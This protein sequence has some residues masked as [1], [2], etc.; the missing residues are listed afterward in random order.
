MET[1]EWKGMFMEFI[2]LPKIKIQDENISKITYKNKLDK[3]YRLLEMGPSLIYYTLWGA[4]ESYHYDIDHSSVWFYETGK[5][6]LKNYSFRHNGILLIIL[7]GYYENGN[8]ESIEYSSNIVD[9]H[10][11][12]G[13][14]Y[15]TWHKNGNISYEK[16]CINGVIHRT[17]GP[18]IT[19]YYKNGNVQY[20]QYYSHGV[21][22]FEIN[23]RINGDIIHPPIVD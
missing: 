12:G 23:Y 5:V 1:Q 9:T 3:T 11:I 10:K 15:I 2:K 19:R 21:F 14:A 20:E 8:I 17:N 13:P 18:A 22:R 7:I 6:S 16:Y 4:I